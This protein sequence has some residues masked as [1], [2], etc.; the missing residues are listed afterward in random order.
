M[1][2]KERLGKFHSKVFKG[3]S[4]DELRT[5]GVKDKGEGKFIRK[6][7]S[8]DGETFDEFLRQAEMPREQVR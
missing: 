3:F 4:P 1:S 8:F 5:F 6:T 2:N 7:P